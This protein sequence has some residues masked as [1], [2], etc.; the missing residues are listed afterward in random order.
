MVVLLLVERIKSAEVVPV[1]VVLI[2]HVIANSAQKLAN[3][4]VPY[5][6][7]FSKLSAH[8]D[9]A[10]VDTHVNCIFTTTDRGDRRAALFP[11]P[12]HPIAVSRAQLYMSR[13][14]YNLTVMNILV[15]YRIHTLH[16]LG[17]LLFVRHPTQ[18]YRAR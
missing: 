1:T 16:V 18:P 14:S 9:T 5:T 6:C 13:R 15:Q 10:C 17:D 8:N 12:T 7:Q 2:S 3:L 11:S 4:I